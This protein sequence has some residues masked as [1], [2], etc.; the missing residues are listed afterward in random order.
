M[1][2]IEKIVFSLHEGSRLL[3]EKFEVDKTLVAKL[4][5]RIIYLKAIYSYISNKRI[6]SVGYM[7]KML[8]A[9]PRLLLTKE[10]WMLIVKNFIPKQLVLFLKKKLS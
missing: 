2:D 7:V 5:I 3:Q 6:A 10:P 1:N 9:A 8:F 4:E